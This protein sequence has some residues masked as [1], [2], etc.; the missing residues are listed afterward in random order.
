MAQQALKTYK[1]FWSPTGQHIAT[2]DACTRRDAV[3]MAPL[4]Y[5]KYLGEIYAQEVGA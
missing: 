2:V 4:P 3:R 1:L 5:R